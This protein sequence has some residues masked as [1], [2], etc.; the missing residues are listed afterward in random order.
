MST[1]EQDD[2]MKGEDADVPAEQVP[3]GEPD[4]MRQPASTAEGP[5]PAPPGDDVPADAPAEGESFDLARSM[6]NV[7]EGADSM[8]AVPAPPVFQP[9]P[10]PEAS[11]DDLVRAVKDGQEDLSVFHGC[12]IKRM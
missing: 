7:V 11:T 3:P 5:L 6:G 10:K 4:P 12:L 8:S 1:D 2:P 9:N